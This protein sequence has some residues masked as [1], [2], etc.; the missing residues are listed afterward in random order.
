MRFTE[1][2]RFTLGELREL[3][4]YLGRTTESY[5]ATLGEL[6]DSLGITELLGRTMRGTEG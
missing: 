5:R 1:N 3:Q 2:Y 6:Q 4:N